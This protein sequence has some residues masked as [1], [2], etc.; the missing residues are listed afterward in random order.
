MDSE[1]SS[2]CQSSVTDWLESV[3]QGK[4]SVAQKIWARYVEQLVRKASKLL[5][6][7][8]RTMV[9][10]EDVAQEAFSGFFRGLEQGRFPQL[11]DRNDLW[12]I[13][14]VLASRR[15]A[16]YQRQALAERRGGGNACGDSGIHLPPACDYEARD[17]FDSLEALPVTPESAED[18]LKLIVLSFPELAHFNLQHIALDRAANY[19]DAE[20]ARR[21]GISVRSVERKLNLIRAIL[22]RSADPGL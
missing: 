14:I 5:S 4:P 18:L 10:A 2:Q 9:D 3:K 15:A 12:Q 7:L 16:D 13:L 20:V 11:H 22:N 1:R 8:P 21:H 19:T 6:K 17:P